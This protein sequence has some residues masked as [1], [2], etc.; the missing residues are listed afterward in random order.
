MLRILWL[1][2]HGH[3]AA[4]TAATSPASLDELASARLLR[5]MEGRRVMNA[6]EPDGDDIY[7]VMAP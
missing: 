4:E 1:D 6:I 7:V 2:S 3:I 5:A